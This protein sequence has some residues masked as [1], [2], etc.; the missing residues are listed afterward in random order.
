M[1]VSN[2][3]KQRRSSIDPSLLQPMH[4]QLNMLS[5]ES[6]PGPKF[7]LLFIGSGN[8]NFGTDEGPWNHSKRAEMKW[9]TRLN[10]VGIVDPNSAR[11]DLELGKKRASFV[12]PAYSDTK[13]FPNVDAAKEGLTADE[14]PHAIIVG[15]PPQF[16][17]GLAPPANLELAL[18]E[19]FPE[20]ALFLEK[21]VT[22]GDAED[23]K[24]VGKR[25]AAKGNVVSVGYMLRYSRA[26][27]TMI[28]IIE[29]KD[30]TVMCTSARYIC[31]YEKIAKED[32]WDK[33]R[34]CGPI[35][36]QATHFCDLSRYFGG[37]VALDSVQAHS[38]EWNEEPGKLSK[39]P[40]EESKIPAE[41]RIPRFTTSSWK[42][43]NGAVGSLVHGVALQDT[44]YYTELTVF[45]DGYQLRLVDPYNNPTLYI[46]APGSD[47][48]VMQ[49]FANDDP[50][51]SELSN[52]GDLIERDSEHN[53]EKPLNTTVLSSYEDAVQ[54]YQL[55]WAIRLSSEKGRKFPVQ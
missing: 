5:F 49:T 39:M 23:A 19:A 24:E 54:T 9:G 38:V 41:Q 6:L 40:I 33:A 37:D 46:R 13:W 16:R 3:Q 4:R 27:Q 51:F 43:S 2:V 31:A 42:Y 50:F 21:P 30:L 7:N 48:E 52:F 17:G 11:A 36:E 14:Q 29:E 15:A 12:A 55:S 53:K 45:A 32:W 44:D 20:T 35:V 26:V 28:K 10:V 25:I 22:T 47:A 8:I 1:S 34:S 18:L